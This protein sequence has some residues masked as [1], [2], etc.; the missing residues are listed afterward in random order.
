MTWLDYVLLAVVGVA[1]F[2]AIRSTL[3]SF[4]DG[5]CPGCGGS[6]GCC[7]D[8]QHCKSKCDCKK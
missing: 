8:C 4:K 5:K 1:L 6:D 7:G 3:R 2:L